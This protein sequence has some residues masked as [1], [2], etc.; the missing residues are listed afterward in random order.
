MLVH[1]LFKG[2]LRGLSQNFAP[3]R[4]CSQYNTFTT[5]FKDMQEMCNNLGHPFM[6][7]GPLA[8]RSTVKGFP[9][10]PVSQTRPP[11]TCKVK[12][13]TQTH[14]S[15]TEEQTNTSCHLQKVIH[16][17][18]KCIIASL[19]FRTLI[20]RVFTAFQLKNEKPIQFTLAVNDKF[21]P[22]ASIS[23]NLTQELVVC[24]QSSV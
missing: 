9:S 12:H 17:V 16:H 19:T 5:E 6:T 4:V 20:F 13:T 8:L 22:R 15:K 21:I 3:E 10:E 11:C 23:F 14:Q 24:Q 1:G 2:E 18:F 7:T